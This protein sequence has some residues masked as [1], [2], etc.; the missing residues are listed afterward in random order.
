MDDTISKNL[1]IKIL[2]QKVLKNCPSWMVTIEEE[3]KKKK[4]QA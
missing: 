1:S 4:C 2:G 3:N